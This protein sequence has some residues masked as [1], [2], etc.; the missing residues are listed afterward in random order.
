MTSIDSEAPRLGDAVVWFASLAV[1]AWSV[2]A[3]LASDD[4]RTLATLDTCV[5]VG[6]AETP[7]GLVVCTLIAENSK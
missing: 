1:I 3:S 2:W 7:S 5:R 4:V 6:W